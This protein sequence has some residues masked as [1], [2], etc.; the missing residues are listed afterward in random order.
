[1]IIFY[2]GLQ[3]QKLIS[4]MVSE[5]KCACSFGCWVGLAIVFPWSVLDKAEAEIGFMIFNPAFMTLVVTYIRQ[6]IRT[7]L[8]IYSIK[9]KAKRDTPTSKGKELWNQR[10][11]LRNLQWTTK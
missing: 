10:K 4:K 3:N 7:R 9:P 8:S 11:Y 2:L 5:E 6:P 1:V